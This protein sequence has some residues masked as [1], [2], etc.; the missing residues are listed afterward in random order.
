MVPNT[1][2][3]SQAHY[4]IILNDRQ[5]LFEIWLIPGA[6]EAG[7]RLARSARVEAAGLPEKSGSPN[8][9]LNSFKIGYVNLCNIR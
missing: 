2:L 5:L 1:D 3:L 8:A 4:T 6:P 9:N 7:H